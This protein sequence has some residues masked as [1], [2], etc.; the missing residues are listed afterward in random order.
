[1]LTSI[2][3]V[4]LILN[5]TNDP[6]TLENAPPVVIRTVPESGT[7]VDAATVKELQITFSKPMHTGWTGFL[8]YQ[9]INTP[10]LPES[11]RYSADGRTCTTAVR[12]ES[13]KT[14]A[15]WLNQPDQPATL[16]GG[17]CDKGNRRSVPYLLIFS[18]KR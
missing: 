4:V 3:L 7:M 11:A 10:K 14:Y 1:M 12:L 2:C 13:G 16:L 17:F 18:T 15:L 6:L 5:R 8:V 9:T